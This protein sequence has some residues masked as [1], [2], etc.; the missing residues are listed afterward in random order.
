MSFWK[1]LFK[2]GEGRAASAAQ[3][4]GTQMAERLGEVNS[5]LMALGD[6]VKTHSTPENEILVKVALTLSSYHLALTH[7]LCRSAFGEQEMLEVAACLEHGHPEQ[8]A[9]I[10]AV[11]PIVNDILPDDRE[12]LRNDVL[13]YLMTGIS[14]FA[15]TA[16]H[17]LKA[18]ELK[19]QGMSEEQ[20]DQFLKTWKTENIF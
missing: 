13:R 6:Y 20:T 11:V 2:G 12:K 3:Q 16:R 1:R 19:E 14:A 4:S 18:R 15:D 8:A 10:R 5:V 17:L 9:R 7:L